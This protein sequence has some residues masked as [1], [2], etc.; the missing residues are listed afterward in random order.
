MNRELIIATGNN[1]KL[2][3]ISHILS[4]LPFA[5]KSLRDYWDP[6][7]VI[8]E[9][10]STFY[11]NAREKANWV[12]SKKNAMTLADDSGLEVDFLQGRP[13]IH[14]ARFAG[15]PGSDGENIKKLLSL[16]IKCP[17]EARQARFKC[18]LVLT[19]SLTEE[20][21]AEGVCEG[22][23]GYAVAGKNGFGYDPLFIPHGYQATFAQLDAS[24]KNNI[25]HRG[26]ALSVLKEKLY[27]RFF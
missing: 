4:G 16:M 1:G 25:S 22:A 2:K 20:I 26:K 12:F 19:L 18:V 5:I 3:E 10:G 8:P 6:V 14:S 21:V 17:K 13:G 27:E 11:E 23:I 9:T 24:T 7:P 15:D